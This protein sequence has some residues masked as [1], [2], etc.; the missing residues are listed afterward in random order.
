MAAFFA[1]TPIDGILGLGFQALADDGVVPVFNVMVQENLVP[2]P[3]FQIFLDSR[4]FTNNAA[5]VFGG[6][7]TQFFTGALR[8]VPLTS[9]SYY[10]IQL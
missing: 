5:I 1:Q 10:V 3:Q 2:K 8:W 4:P 9:E 6:Y 7:N